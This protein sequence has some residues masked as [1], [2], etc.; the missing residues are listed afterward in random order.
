MWR[1]S[2]Q[3]VLL[4]IG[5]N[6]YV[7]SSQV[8]Q[9][10]QPRVLQAMDSSRISNCGS[11]ARRWPAVLEAARK[12]A[13]AVSSRSKLAPSAPSSLRSFVSASQGGEESSRVPESQ[14]RNVQRTL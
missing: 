8:T 11:K 5:V 2:S 1:G 7:T 10:F 3:R 6:G 9:S 4:T 14:D 13:G 12:S